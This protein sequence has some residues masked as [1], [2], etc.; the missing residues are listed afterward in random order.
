MN[1]ELLRSPW[2]LLSVVLLVAGAFLLSVFGWPIA[3]LG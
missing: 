3:G 2:L 1:S